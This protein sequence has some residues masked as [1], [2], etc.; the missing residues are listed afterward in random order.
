MNT[1]VTNNIA[2]ANGTSLIGYIT[3]TYSTLCEKLGEPL[4]D[5]SG[6]RKVTCQW[7]IEF[8]DGSV[9]TIYDWK[10]RATPTKQYDWHVGGRGT[11]ILEKTS[12]L[13]E[14]PVRRTMFV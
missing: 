2:K 10:T 5:H 9:G 13:T 4:R 11:N 14:L 3:S 6:D 8:E 12:K 1:K 7:I